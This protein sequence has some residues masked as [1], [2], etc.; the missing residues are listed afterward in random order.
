MKLSNVIRGF[1]V[2]LIAGAGAVGTQGCITDE[3]TE[4]DESSVS[5]GDQGNEAAGDENVGEISQPVCEGYQPGAFCT[6]RCGGNWYNLGYPGYGNCE[7]EGKKH[8]GWNL[9][10]SCW[11][12]SCNACQ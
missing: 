11:S 2:L 4:G 6:A 1:C 10:V 9:E 7:E 5:D 12:L 3:P 8:C